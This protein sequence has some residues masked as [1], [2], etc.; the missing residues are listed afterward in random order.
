MVIKELQFSHIL[1]QSRDIDFRRQY[2]D[3]VVKLCVYFPN[4]WIPGG[5]V[6]NERYLSGLQVRVIGLWLRKTTVR[7][8]DISR[9][10]RRKIAQRQ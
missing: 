5:R 8:R 1:N 2:S 3:I 10:V 4:G 6:W 7:L 9:T